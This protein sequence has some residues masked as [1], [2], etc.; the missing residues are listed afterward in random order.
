M[1]RGTVTNG[2]IVVDD[3]SRLIEGASVQISQSARKP[4]A[5]PA[6]SKASRRPSSSKPRATLASLAFDGCPPDMATQHDHYATGAPKRN[7]RKKTT[8]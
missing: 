5:K 7:Q 4:D 8:G 1:L 3:P 2:K 6:R